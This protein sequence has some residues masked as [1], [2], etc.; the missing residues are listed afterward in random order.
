MRKRLVVH[1]RVQAVAFRMYAQEMA[2]RLDLH[3]WIRNLAD[4]RTVELV[5]EGDD[6]SVQAFV[7]WCREGPPTADVE[8]VEVEDDDS[9]D[10]LKPFAILPTP[11]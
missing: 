1:G 2:W 9:T 11:S 3:G 10:T 8:R 5:A 7:E 4:R 6:D